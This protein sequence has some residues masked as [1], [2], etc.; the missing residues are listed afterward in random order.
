MTGILP[1][2]Q[3]AAGLQLLEDAEAGLIELLLIYRLPESDT[4]PG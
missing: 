2:D 1:L 3:W 4:A